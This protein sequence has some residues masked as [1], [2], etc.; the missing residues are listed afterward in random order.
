MTAEVSAL[1]RVRFIGESTF[2]TSRI[3]DIAQFV[4]VPAIEKT[5]IFTGLEAHQ[6]PEVVQTHVHGYRDSKMVK[7]LRSCTLDF[8]M[9]LAGTGN[10]HN[11]ATL[12]PLPTLTDWQM[13]LLEFLMGGSETVTLGTPGTA[14]TVESTG[15][16]T[17]AIVMKTNTLSVA[18]PGC[19]FACVMPSGLIEA[20]EIRSYSAGVI[21]PK[22]AFSDVP[23]E[24]SPIYFGTTFHLINGL[25]ADL[26]SIQAICEGVALEDSFLGMGM[27]GTYGIDVAPGALAKLTVKLM[28]AAWSKKPEGTALT[29]PD[30]FTNFAPL[31]NMSSELL[32]GKVQTRATWTRSTTTCT[33]TSYAHGMASGETVT[34]VKSNDITAT[35][36]GNEVITVTGVD[37][38]TFACAN[39]GITTGGTL[40]YIAC[41]L[42]NQIRHS[43]STWQPG[44]VNV[45]ITSP[46]GLGNSNITGWKR[47]RSRAVTGSFTAYDEPSIPSLIADEN[48]ES[49][50][51]A[52]TNET[53]L[54]IYQQI[55]MTTRGIVLITA[56][57]VQINVVPTRADANGLYA[58]VV[59]WSG[60]NDL[61]SAETSDVS[62]SAQRITVF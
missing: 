25:G 49:W 16:T 1:Q 52:D 24:D 9:H 48:V 32:V 51:D 10:M 20:R 14:C 17:R 23:A 35:P 19:A 4:D 3:A 45:P 18:P 46:E 43:A 60:R 57:T 55:G 12:P 31:T 61:S 7:G 2:N 42:R 58:Q 38:F 59:S 41:Q 28:G 6:E 21:V 44:L 15:T 22:I 33:V 37:T 39:A 50:Q 30:A 5:P 11:G 62:S 8:S 47:G 34:L 56:P 53:D 13:S 27:C 54:A 36:L 29:A 26:A 40:T